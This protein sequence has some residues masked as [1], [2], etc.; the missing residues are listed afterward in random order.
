MVI[1]HLISHHY[2]YEMRQTNV[3][4]EACG[5]KDWGWSALRMSDTPTI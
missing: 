2:E 3:T 4:K 5:Q 1:K